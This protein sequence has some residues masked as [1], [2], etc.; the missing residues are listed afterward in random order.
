MAREERTG[1]AIDL[2]RE[3]ITKV[4]DQFGLSSLYQSCAELTARENRTGEAIELLRGGITKVPPEF[5]L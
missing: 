1:E 2:L 3:G 5:S 4:P